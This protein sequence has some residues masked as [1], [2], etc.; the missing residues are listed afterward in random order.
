ML[1]VF[2]RLE[3]GATRLPQMKTTQAVWWHSC[4]PYPAYRTLRK[5]WPYGCFIDVTQKRARGMPEL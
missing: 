3:A 1:K 4:R 5:E 2:L